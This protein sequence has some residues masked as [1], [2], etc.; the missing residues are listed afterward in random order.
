MPSR[1]RTVGILIAPPR[2]STAC[3]IRKPG[4]PAAIGQPV[5]LHA[6][7]LALVLHPELKRRVGS[8][9][10]ALPGRRLEAIAAVE[11][12]LAAAPED[13][14]AW[15]LKRLLY[16]E[17]T[18]REYEAGRVAEFDHAYVQQLGLALIGDATRL[19]ATASS[20]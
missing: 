5:L 18:E 3:S 11:L 13:E 7:H 20:F 10:L 1:R 8:P 2:L 12:A 4:L 6:W 17:L 16:S 15:T 9:Q 14:A 19:A